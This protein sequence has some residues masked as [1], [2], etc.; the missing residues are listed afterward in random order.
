MPLR[1]AQ[2][3]GGARWQWN[4]EPWQWLSE[5]LKFLGSWSPSNFILYSLGNINEL[6]SYTFIYPLWNS[7][8]LEKQ[9]IHR[10]THLHFPIFYHPL[11]HRLLYIVVENYSNLI[12]FL[13]FESCYP[14]EKKGSLHLLKPT[15]KDAFVGWIWV[16][17]ESLSWTLIISPFFPSKEL[18]ITT[19][20]ILFKT[21]LEKR[22]S[23]SSSV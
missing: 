10:L 11:V 17:E 5:F 18:P 1:G 14:G 6:T 22:F 2:G 9:I 23:N 19:F 7:G 8:N 13:L 12:L 21:D 16:W 20:Q 15:P 3:K 4:P